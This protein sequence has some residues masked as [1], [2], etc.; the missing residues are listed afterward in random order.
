MKNN[1]MSCIKSYYLELYTNETKLPVDIKFK[2]SC[3]NSNLLDTWLLEYC[4][5]LNRL[6]Y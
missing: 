6:N 5:V 1:F 4:S 3:A 2:I